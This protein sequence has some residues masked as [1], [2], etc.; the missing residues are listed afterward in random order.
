MSKRP[1]SPGRPTGSR[2]P[3]VKRT[4]KS[5]TAVRRASPSPKQVGR[6]E[7]GG[8]DERGGV[9]KRGS[10]RPRRSDPR[11]L[12]GEQVEGRQAVRELL[13]AG[14]RHVRELLVIRDGGGAS[15]RSHE[16]LQDI[17]DLAGDLDVVVREVSHNRMLRE[18]RTDAPQ[19]VIAHAAPLPESDL[20]D[21]VSATAAH[22]PFL[23]AVDGVTDPGNL[24]ALIRS[25][26]CAGA[27]GLILPRHRAVHVTPAAA[28]A[29]AGA[30]EYLAISVVGG[31]PSAIGHLRERGVTVVGLDPGGAQPLFNLPIQADVP[32]CLVLGS[33]GRGMSRLVRQRCDLVAR[34]PLHGQLASLNVAA[35]GTVACYEIARR[36]QG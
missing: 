14:R 10:G 15:G 12:G 33:E 13:L 22:V 9:P 21:L 16:S 20:D 29:A 28:K 8:S 23:V 18:A 6:R 3:P 36:R 35:A 34:L 7:S 32:I 26:E 5:A 25:A 30:V 19:G 27:T 4:R 17:V 11:G 31:L 24:G 1:T 2:K